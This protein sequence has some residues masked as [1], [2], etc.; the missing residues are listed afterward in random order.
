[1]SLPRLD[2]SALTHNAAHWPLPG[3]VL[4][5]G[6]LAGLLFVVG[7]LVYLSPSRDRLHQ[8]QA[9]EVALQQHIAQKT[10]LSA[11]LEERARQLALM[12]AKVDGLF[13]AL[14]AESEMPGLLEDI[15]R[16]ALANGLVVEGVAVLDEQSQPLYVEEPLSRRTK[17]CS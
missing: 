11:S 6:A 9:R 15:A 2:L 1:M 17:A 10:V 13:Q 14:P 4:L 5:G 3:K 7:D 16:L 12:Q 8:V